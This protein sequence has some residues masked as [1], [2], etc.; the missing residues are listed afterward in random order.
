M[1]TPNYPTSGPEGTIPVNEAIDWAQNWRTY[2]ATSGQVFNVESF[3]IP[4]I[5]FKNILLHNPDAESVRAYIGLEDATDPTTA[6]LMLVPVVDG[7]DVVV[8]PTTGNGGVGDG[9]QSNV[10]DVTKPCPPTCA[11]PTSPIRG[12]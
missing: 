7:H 1:S 6:K 3:E 12:F 10:Y 11:P 8:I 4:I 2:I 9:D 5:D